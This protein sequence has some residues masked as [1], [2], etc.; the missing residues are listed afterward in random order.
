MKIGKNSFVGTVD[1]MRHHILSMVLPLCD[2]KHVAIEGL[3]SLF[4]CKPCSILLECTAQLVEADK[5]TLNS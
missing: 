4:D 3:Q 2:G 1:E 5:K